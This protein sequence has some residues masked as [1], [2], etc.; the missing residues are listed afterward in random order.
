MG[1]AFRK[2]GISYLMN[3]SRTWV[4]LRT[5]RRLQFFAWI[6]QYYPHWVFR[7]LALGTKVPAQHAVPDLKKL[8][9]ELG[10]LFIKAG[11]FL[12]IRCDLFSEAVIAALTPLQDKV[13][14]QPFLEIEK[15]LENTYP[16]PL[17]QLFSSIDSTPL[18]S[19]S[20]AQVH[21]ARTMDGQQVVIKV[22]R[23]HIKAQIQKD[24]F[25][26]KKLALFCDRLHPQLRHFSFPG[27]V[28]E[29]A[30]TLE[31]E[32]DL[33]QEGANAAQLHHNFKN[34][35][36]LYVPTI[37]WE[38][39]Y[40]SVLVMEHIH[41][42]PINDHL[43]LREHNTNLKLLAENGVRIFFTQVFRDRFFH[44]DMHPGNVF[45]DI[46]HPQHPRYMAVDFGIMGS[47]NDQDH[48]YLFENFLALFKQDYRRVA[49]LH[50]ASGWVPSST[51]L[52]HFESSI[53][54]VC[55]PLF[56]KPLSEISFGTTLLKLLQTAHHFQMQ[57]QPQLLL[58]QKTLV[59]IEGVG[60]Q[61]YPSLDIWKI[62]TPFFKQ[63][64]RERYYPSHLLQTLKHQIPLWLSQIQPPPAK[65]VTTPIQPPL[66]FWYSLS[67]LLIIL[68][69]ALLALL[70]TILLPI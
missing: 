61:L 54:G 64:A 68:T 45:V 38:L 35:P 11:Q 12:S 21:A 15:I 41:G 55:A 30:Y 40:T 3:I 60:Q 4:I 26:L 52:Q 8:C 57:I 46:S 43:T 49:Q 28:R 53:R 29:W 58:L 33:L 44:A 1:A 31:Q 59:T 70:W 51:S 66:F 65:A 6:V 48:Y 50:I 23:P 7:L 2:S 9:E 24:L 22:L 34:S 36:L 13:T 47:L 20:I 69:G 5:M 37:Y 19:A 62:A 16:L 18:G 39:S 56:D 27:L 32:C 63:S 25:I 14:P 17:N 67:I 42:V 10:P